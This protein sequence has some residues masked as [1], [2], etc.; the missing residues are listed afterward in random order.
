MHYTQQSTLWSDEPYFSEPEQ[1]I[2]YCAGSLILGTLDDDGN[3][4]PKDSDQ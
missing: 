3:F 2:P 1:G 4:I